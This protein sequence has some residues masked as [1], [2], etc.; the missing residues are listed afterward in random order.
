MLLLDYYCSGLSTNGEHKLGTVS[1]PNP[2]IKEIRRGL[3]CSRKDLQDLQDEEVSIIRH[4]A[5]YDL[6]L[7]NN[8]FFFYSLLTQD[9]ITPHI[10]K[11]HNIAGEALQKFITACLLLGQFLSLTSFDKSMQ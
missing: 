9:Y 3:G 6:N 5:A 8:T 10:G 2:N 11:S 7:L 4:T 1:E